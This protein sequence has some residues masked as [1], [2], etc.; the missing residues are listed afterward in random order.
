MLPLYNSIFQLSVAFS[1][2]DQMDL[3]FPRAGVLDGIIEKSQL[4]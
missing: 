1:N 4:K 2:S 3:K